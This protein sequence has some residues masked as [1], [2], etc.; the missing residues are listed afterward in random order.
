L[1]KGTHTAG[2]QAVYSSGSSPIIYSEEF[3]VGEY[4]GITP[5]SLSVVMLYPNPFTNEI[6]VSNSSEVKNIQITNA[7]G[8]KV[9]EVRFNGKSISTGEL[10]NGI[11]F[12]IIESVT[13]AKVVHKM[14][15]K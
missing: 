1:E 14:I 11:Y 12:V 9:K 13:G 3:V 10:S 7:T 5:S 8:Q 2:V 15:K 6:N 4:L